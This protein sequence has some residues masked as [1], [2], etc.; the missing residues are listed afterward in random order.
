MQTLWQDF[1]YGER[2]LRRN[3]GFTAVAVIALALGIGGNTAVFSVIN[4]LLLRPPPFKDADRLVY[5]W[6]TNPQLNLER[7]IVSAPDF[8]DWREQNRVF[9]HVSAFRTWFYRLN[10]RSEAEQVWG[11]RTSANFFRLLGIEPGPGRGFLPEEEG[12]GRDHV[13]IISHRL[14]ERRFGADP[15]LVG[16]SITIDDTA[17]TV[18]GI[19]PRD[20]NLFGSTR[21]YDIWMPFD[22]TRGATRR[23]DYSVIVFARL[24]AGVTLEQAQAE[25]SSIAERLEQ[26]YSVANKNRGVKV[27]TLHENQVLSLRPALLILLAAVGFVLLI[28]CANVANLL[29]ARAATRQAETA[30][31][32]AL[33]ASRS[34]IIRQLL[35][36]SVLLALVGGALGLLFALWGL[37]LLRA[38]LPVGVDEI[39]HADWIGID[40]TAL[41]FTFLMSLLTGIVFGIA[42]ALQISRPEL[43]QTLRHGGRGLESGRG[44]RLRDSFVIAEIALATVL[45]LGAGLL[46]RSFGKLT[47]VEPGFDAE[48]VLTMQVWLPESRYVD[49]NRIAEFYQQTLNRIREIPGVKSASAVNFLPFSG[50]GDT[51]GFSIEGRASTVMGQDAV[52][53][54]RVIDSDYFRAMQIPLLKGRPF[55]EHDSDDAHGVA[56][57]NEAMAQRYWPDEEPLGKHIRPAFPATKTPWR[58]EAGDVWLTIVGVVQDVKEFGFTDETPPEFY[59][60]YLQ[61]PSALMRLVVRTETRPPNL[62]SVIREQVQAVDRD[63]PITEIK[64]MYEFISDSVY[65]RRFNM[66]LLGVFASV[67]LILAAVGV[68]GVMNYSVTQRTRE[69]G[70][71]MA[72]GASTADVLSAVFSRGMKLSL[73]GVAIGLACA[74]ELTQVMQT[75]LF[76]VGA[77]DALTFVEVALMLTAVSMV[78]CYI[79]ARRATRVDPT[80]ALRYE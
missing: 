16:E 75:L 1:R 48:N 2:T 76:G 56:L 8:A 17:F 77:T 63:Q 57:I 33:G 40:R 18:I 49:G 37:D 59:L 5:L 36:E 20:F 60:P 22:F 31:R 23:D 58:P 69:L 12:P 71:R 38:N 26:Q 46:I 51:T 7:G 13:V 27:I 70:I 19:L 30:V 45:L 24:K 4:A 65:R 78:A 62:V 79:P 34:R 35:T 73:A 11:V 80:V 15:D 14:W 3:P 66:V 74:F 10:G 39:A 52:A 6:E 50:W 55:G 44:R 32:M 29:L 25:M 47:A 9:E 53:Q 54:Y 64:S 41:G 68:Y 21:A 72:L 67:A 61:N 42:P 43:N 28:A